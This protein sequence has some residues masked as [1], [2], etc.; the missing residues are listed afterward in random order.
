MAANGLTATV[1]GSTAAPGTVPERGCIPWSEARHVAFGA[2]GPLP[3]VAV[4]HNSLNVYP[5]RERLA[6]PRLEA[7]IPA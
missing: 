1:S 7:T 4:P 2:A 6:R 5:G 3:P